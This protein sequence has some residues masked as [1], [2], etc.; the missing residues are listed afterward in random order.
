M[1]RKREMS[2]TELKR[3]YTQWMR[4]FVH[5]IKVLVNEDEKTQHYIFFILLQECLF[6]KT[7][8]PAFLEMYKRDDTFYKVDTDG[9][10]EDYQV[11]PLH[12]KK[13]KEAFEDLITGGGRSKF[14]NILK[15]F[16]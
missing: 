2:D 10:L 9:G 14:T 4:N 7:T 16:K 13:L 1:K 11:A 15:E 5:G 3:K 6:N 8:S 12:R